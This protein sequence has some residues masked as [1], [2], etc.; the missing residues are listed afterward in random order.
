MSRSATARWLLCGAHV[1]RQVHAQEPPQQ[2]AEV[3][4]V[5]PPTPRAPGQSA[6]TTAEGRRTPGTAGDP[7]RAVESLPGVGRASFD[8]G[9]LIVWG[10]AS[11]ESKVLVD[12]VE[13]PTLYHLGGHRTVV[14]AP[15]VD[16]LV[17]TAGGQGA[18]YGRG[19]GG[20][21]RVKTASLPKDGLHG[22]AQLDLI[23][24]GASAS[25]ASRGGDVRAFVAARAS[26]LDRTL[27]ALVSPDVGELVPIPR[28]LDRQAK[29]SLALR[30]EEAVDVV[31]LG[32]SDS[33]TRAL[34]AASAT[35]ARREETSTG[36][37][38]V[39]VRYARAFDDGGAVEVTPFFGRDRQS[40]TLASGLVTAARREDTWRYGVRASYQASA[41][42]W[43]DVTL[44][45]DASGAT[46]ALARSG[47]LTLPPREGDPYVFGQPPGAD[48]SSD[49]WSTT[50]VDVAPYATG[51]LRV[52]AWT[53]S[54]GLRLDGYL[55]EGS[56]S[57]P[58]AGDTPVIGY[59]RF[60]PVAAPRL[61]VGWAAD[62]RITVSLAA[63]VYHQPPDPGD[64]SAVFGTPTLEL[65]RANHVALGST[66]GV[67]PAMTVEVTTFYKEMD[68]LVVRS[69]RPAPLLAQALTQDG[70]GRAFGVQTLLRHAR[71]RG[72]FGW[73]SHTASRSERRYVGDARYRTFDEDRS[74]VLALVVG[75]E[76]GRWSAGVRLRYTT[77]LP[78]TPVVGAIYETTSGVHQ[79]IF[80]PQNS[81]RMPDFYQ[82]DLRLEHTLARAPARVSVYLDVLNATNHRNVEEL[83][84]SADYRRKAGVTGLPTL[85]VLG[86]R[87]ER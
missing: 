81:A 76:R 62:R 85:A 24:A 19:L 20:I 50:L 61:A 41:A 8:G 15:L 42:R 53:F 18:P 22:T 4:V 66:L 72:V 14:G 52:G 13:I 63:G 5:A 70:E 9:R 47:S 83:A 55:V 69:R 35:R 38:R 65:S 28:Y 2:P 87:A 77:G 59:S 36:F 31:W 54:P 12:G 80:G 75:V 43:L 48:V 40:L 68:H 26:H 58:R 11:G 30:E 23:D 60:H 84:Y 34:D 16:S 10:A 56:R 44:G 49:D 86:V 82:L 67:A 17:L 57:T 32:S 29:L 74:H 39:Y 73:L 46:S 33:I 25:A 64:L 79:P 45:V 6:V 1:A 3:R 7:L 37:E 27:G 71:R 51:E 21:V 78:R